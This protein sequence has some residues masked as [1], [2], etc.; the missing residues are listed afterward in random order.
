MDEFDSDYSFSESEEFPLNQASSSA[1]GGYPALDKGKGTS[2]AQSK[3]G[4]GQ[5]DATWKGKGNSCTLT[6]EKQPYGK[7]QDDPGW[8]VREVPSSEVKHLQPPTTAGSLMLQA[9]AE[10]K[11]S[12]AAAKAKRE[13]EEARQKAAQDEAKQKAAQEE[14]R[15]KAAQEEER[16]GKG[17]QRDRS[18][19][20]YRQK[21]PAQHY[22]YPEAPWHRPWNQA[23]K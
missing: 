5:P 10:E 20:P 19:E 2:K 12:R 3:D 9:Q 4:Y 1:S 11:R 18:P 6:H 13:A 7:T 15:Q 22:Q 23:P 14:A 21:R 16:K 17:Q 8:S